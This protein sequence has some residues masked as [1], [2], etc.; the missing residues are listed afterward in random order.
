MLVFYKELSE[1][2]DL[3]LTKREGRTGKY[4]LERLAD[5]GQRGL[6]NDDRGPDP[7]SCLLYWTRTIL[8]KTKNTRLLAV[9]M[10]KFGT[11]KNQ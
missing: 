1:W 7:V 3:L 9:S 11:R 8:S 10:A 4:W 2:I 5:Q 6:H